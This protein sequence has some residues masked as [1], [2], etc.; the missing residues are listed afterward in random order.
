MKKQAVTI[1]TIIGLTLGAAGI[2]AA[3]N[4]IPRTRSGKPDL[5][6]NYDISSLTPFQRSKKHGDRLF[7]TVKEARGMETEAAAYRDKRATDSNP[8]RQAPQ[9]GGNVGDYN[10]FWYDRGN[11]G[12]SI[13]GR[14]RTSILTDPRN[15]RMPALSATGKKRRSGLPRF[16]WQNKGEAWWLETG[17]TPYD[18]PETMVLGVRCIYQPTASLPIRPLPYNNL[19]TIVQTDDHV[20]INIEWMHWVRVVRIDA[21]HL[22]KEIRSL[23]GDSI[24]WWEEDT[25]VVETTNFLSAPGVPREGLRV[26]E[27]FSPVDENG[28]LYAF[29][30]EDPDYESSYSGELLWPKTR[31]RAYEYA[32]HE[33]NYAMG[34]ML[35][36]ARLLEKEWLAKKEGQVK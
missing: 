31:Q 5:S 27:H 25:L 4:E 19:K 29:T 20:M 3:E 11:D 36:G 2:R 23:A 7:L 30:V 18:G 15:G 24:G 8:N 13:D 14:F 16:A 35:R 10:D 9:S 21:E 12:F 17:D 22:P 26:V 33:G 32:C 28:L 6:G 1:V 34:N